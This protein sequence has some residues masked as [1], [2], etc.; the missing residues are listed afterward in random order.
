MT[1]PPNEL[2]FISCP[3]CGYVKHI[4]WHH[5]EDEG[6]GL[7]LTCEDCNLNFIVYRKIHQR[8]VNLDHKVVT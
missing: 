8:Y 4:P 1:S 5:L 6:Q 2:E 3:E 7:W